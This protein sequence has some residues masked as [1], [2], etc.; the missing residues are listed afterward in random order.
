MWKENPVQIFNT[1]NLAPDRAGIINTA[2]THLHDGFKEN[3]N[4]QY[5]EQY[6]QQLKATK[7]I[8]DGKETT[9]GEKFWKRFAPIEKTLEKR[10]IQDDRNDF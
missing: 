9:L 10:L 2:F 8:V 4:K 3:L 6:L 1:A 5:T 7:I